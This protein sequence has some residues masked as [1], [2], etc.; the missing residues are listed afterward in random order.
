MKLIKGY[1]LISQSELEDSLLHAEKR[2]VDKGSKESKK[3]LEDLE[4][5]VEKKNKEIERI[6]ENAEE[7]DESANRQI[8]RLE[9]KIEVLEEERDDV[10]EVVKKSM[11]NEDLAAVLTAK[12]EG[13]DKREAKLKDREAK[14]A[15]EEDAKSKAS[16]ADGLADGLRKA[17]EIT[18]KDRENAMKVAMVSAA[19][20][21]PA[22]TMKE[23]NNVHQL[24]AGS[25][26]E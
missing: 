6:K 16:Y 17:H 18:Q 12:K 21:T 3:R 1:T 9:A 23:L 22:E 26:E 7:A 8:E 25:S 14:L 13:L 20:H 2:G 19:S 4:K 5:S 15:D 10:R 24:T 11:E